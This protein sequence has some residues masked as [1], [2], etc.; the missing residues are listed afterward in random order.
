MDFVPDNVH[1]ADLFEEVSYEKSDSRMKAID[2]I[3]N[4]F[5]PGTLFYAAAGL[6]KDGDW[7]S[8]THHLSPRYTT[9][10]DELPHAI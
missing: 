4:R 10:W 5:G 2:S 8:R 3:N 9:K 1:Q 6:R 7:Q